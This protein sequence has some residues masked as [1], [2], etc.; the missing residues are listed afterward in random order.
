VLEQLENSI[1]KSGI[2]K[3]GCPGSGGLFSGF[4]EKLLAAACEGCGKFI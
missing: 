1:I 3:A 4:S 2:Y